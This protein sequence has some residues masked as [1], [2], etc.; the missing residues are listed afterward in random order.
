M[1]IF[2]CM[3]CS[4]VFICFLVEKGAINL[5]TYAIPGEMWG[6]HPKCVQLHKGEGG[7][8][9]HVCVR[10]YTIYFRVFDLKSQLMDLNW[11]F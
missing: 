6:G 7:A 10:T 2:Q 4:N 8:E 5:S 9:P 1:F 11:H 3:R